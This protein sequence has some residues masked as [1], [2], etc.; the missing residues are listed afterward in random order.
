MTT[1]FTQQP[2]FAAQHDHHLSLTPTITYQLWDNITSHTHLHR[3]SRVTDHLSCFT[4]PLSLSNQPVSS[5]HPNQSS[6][7]QQVQ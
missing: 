6:C 4:F 3:L 1:H 5:I 7:L 2:A